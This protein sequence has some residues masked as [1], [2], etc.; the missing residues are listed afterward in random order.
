MFPLFPLLFAM[1]WGDPMP[2]SSFFESRVSNNL[3]HSPLSPSLRLFSPLHFLPLEW[4]H[5]HIWCWIF[6]PA[7]LIPACDSSSL[8]FHMRYSACML[9]KQDDNIYSLVLLLFQF[10]DY[11]V[12]QLLQI[13]SK[14]LPNLCFIM[15]LHNSIQDVEQFKISC[16]CIRLRRSLIMLIWNALHNLRMLLL[17]VY[18]S[19]PD[20]V[21]K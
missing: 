3:F 11:K 18:I 5:L 6:H 12:I 9:N 17:Y 4:Y 10:S 13:T 1:K 16:L 8:A 19:D 21:E 14:I 7:V 2:W 15:S 20:S